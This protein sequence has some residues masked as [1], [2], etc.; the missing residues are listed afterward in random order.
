MRARICTAMLLGVTLPATAALCATPLTKPN[1]VAIAESVRLTGADMPGY[2]EVPHLWPGFAKRTYAAML[3]C[4]GSEQKRLELADLFS[5]D[6]Q[7][8]GATASDPPTGVVT[9]HIVV[10]RS[11]R[12]AANDQRALNSRHGRRCAAKYSVATSPGVTVESVHASVM[13]PPVPHTSATRVTVRFNTGSG[14]D[15]TLVADGFALRRGPVEVV[16][17]FLGSS[18]NASEE[19]RVVQLLA[20]RARQTEMST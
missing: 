18:L 13:P 1:A 11:A 6:F 3:K 5:N 7:V 14:S 8:P 15:Q 10:M 9:S 4:A 19:H 16:V 17:A 2:T 12:A 20:D